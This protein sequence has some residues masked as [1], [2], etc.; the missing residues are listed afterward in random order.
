MIPIFRFEIETWAKH[1]HSA[2][3]QQFGTPRVK[4]VQHRVGKC[5]RSV[6]YR[7]DKTLE[8]FSWEMSALLIGVGNLWV[9]QMMDE[10]G[11][12]RVEGRKL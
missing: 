5:W 7:V 6:M 12:S 2:T 9:V 3:L 1:I 4:V 10:M 11:D 8:W